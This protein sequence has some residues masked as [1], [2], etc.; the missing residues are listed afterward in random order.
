MYRQNSGA[1]IYMGSVHSHE[2]SP[3]K[4][5]YIAAKHGILGFCPYDGERGRQA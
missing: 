1:L 2:A 3:L 5:A 4:S